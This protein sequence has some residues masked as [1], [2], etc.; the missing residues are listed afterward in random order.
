M[1]GSPVGAPRIERITDGVH[2]YIQ[3]DGSWWINNAGFVVGSHGV[4][5]VDTASTQRRAEAFRDAIAGVTDQPVLTLVNTHHHG[6]HT[7]GNYVFDQATVVA[8]QQ[9]RA[10]ALATGLPGPR[11]GNTWHAPEWGELRLSPPTVT[12][13]DGIDLWVDGLCCRVQYIGVPAHTT[14]DSIVWIPDRSV[15]FAGD[16]VFNG[17]TPFLLGGSISGMLAAIRTLRELRPQIIVP[18][19]GDVCGMEALTT[20]SA[21]VEF[22][23]AYAEQAHRRGMTPLEAGRAC[24]LGEFSNLLDAERIV[25]NLHR[26]YAELDGYPPGHPIDK[27]AALADMVAYHGGLLPCHA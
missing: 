19:H 5:A 9:C 12:F 24:D 7:N 13:D 15:L 20:T 1:T 21:Y 6:D 27:R 2:A 23:Q 4:V 10:E 11:Q 14:G 17:G 3:P 26:A 16:L 18:G 22:V 25:G 8:H